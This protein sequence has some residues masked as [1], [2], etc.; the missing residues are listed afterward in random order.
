M[1][2]TDII[3][4]LPVIATRGMV[5]F[6]DHE[7]SLDVGR[8]FSLKSINDSV[9]SYDENIVFVSQV[10]PLDEN[11][12]FDHVYH[13]GTLCKIKRRIRRDNHGTIKLTV[14]GVKRVEILSLDTKDNCLYAFTWR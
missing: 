14:L 12:D 8:D 4:N 11:T 6:T 1:N 5:V 10:N 3:V 9:N 13:F 7:L 2:E